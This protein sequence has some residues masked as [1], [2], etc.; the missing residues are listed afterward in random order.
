MSFTMRPFSSCLLLLAGFTLAA[1]QTGGPGGPQGLVKD[2][3]SDELRKETI[4]GVKLPEGCDT[5]TT[6]IPM[7]KNVTVSYQ[8]P[9][10][11]QSG[12]PLNELGY[13]TIYLSSPGSEAQATRVWTNDARGGANVTI[14][15]VAPPAQDFALCVTATNWSRKESAPALLKPSAQ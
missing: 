11:D 1:C 7:G 12:A 2:A 6:S 10:T 5:S 13:T 9:K 3:K 15:N 8:E 4:I 14:T